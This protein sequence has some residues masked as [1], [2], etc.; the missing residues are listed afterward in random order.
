MNIFAQQDPPLGFVTLVFFAIGASL[1]AWAAIVERLVSGKPVLPYQ[2]RR[3]VPWQVWDLLAVTIFY[4][5]GVVVLIH[6]AQYFWPPET[7]ESYGNAALG[8]TSTAHP[9][10]Q[11]LRVNN[12]AAFLLCGTAAV[13]V[14]PIAE[15]FFFRV[16]L[17]GW[18]EKTERTWRRGL[19]M[20]RRRMPLGAMPI[21]FSSIIFAGQHFREEAP[22]VNVDLFFLLLACDGIAKILTIIFSIVFLHWRVGA[23]AADFGWAPEK[24]LAD[25]RLGLIT[26]AAI[27]VPIYGSLIIVSQLLPKRF[28]P[29]PIPIFFFAVAL[30]LLYNRTH[31]VVPSIAVHMALNATSLAMVYLGSLG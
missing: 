9:I 22:M 16:L 8:Q 30:G 28:A 25:V 13:V 21:L 12:W 3:R 14:A 27:A 1:V 23:T 20:L 18:M 5:A 6:L 4:V 19:P 15:E 11:L 31:R 2:P 26:F 10:I 17:Q 24:F 7:T 29:D